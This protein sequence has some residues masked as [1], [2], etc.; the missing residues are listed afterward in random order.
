MQCEGGGETSWEK[1]D[2]CSFPGRLS[3]Q[4]PLGDRLAKGYARQRHVGEK[5]KRGTGRAAGVGVRFAGL[6]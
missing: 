5:F 1:K 6:T 3:H 4:L 2:T